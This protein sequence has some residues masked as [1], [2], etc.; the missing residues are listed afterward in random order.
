MAS[1]LV[2]ITPLRAVGD[3]FAMAL[4]V[5]VL[6]PTYCGDTA[7]GAGRSRRSG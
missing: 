2:A 3:F 5:V 6:T 1:R 4:D 7:S